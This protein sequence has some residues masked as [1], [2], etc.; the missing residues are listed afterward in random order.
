MIVKW[1][2][3]WLT[4]FGGSRWGDQ[5]AS[6]LRRLRWGDVR[7]RCSSC[8]LQDAVKCLGH[9]SRVLHRTLPAPPALYVGLNPSC[10]SQ[11]QL[12]LSI[13]F[14]CV[15]ESIFRMLIFLCKTIDGHSVFSQNLLYCNNT[16]KV[17][18]WSYKLWG[19]CAFASEPRDFGPGYP[20]T[21]AL[22]RTQ[23]F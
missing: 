6:V 17:L 9:P 16:V 19:G 15:L 21:F 18:K 1:R 22:Y 12:T 7:V 4:R 11:V 8:L 13:L 5:V 14:R 20:S 10:V 2:L 3:S 23:L